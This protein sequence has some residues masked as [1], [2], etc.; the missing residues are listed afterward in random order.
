M[1]AAGMPGELNYF[2]A[3]GILLYFLR[4]PAMAR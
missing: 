2:R 4:N 1:T 3:G